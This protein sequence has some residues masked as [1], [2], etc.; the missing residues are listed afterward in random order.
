MVMA[1]KLSSVLAQQGALVHVHQQPEHE[2]QADAHAARLVHVPEHQRQRQQVGHGGLAP[3]R[4]HVEEAGD[5]QRHCDEEGVDR[6][7]QLVGTPRH[8]HGAISRC[9]TIMAQN[10]RAAAP[11]SGARP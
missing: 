4:Q 3:H 6:Q 5:G 9:R 10:R 11:W 2:G 7:Q 8:D 1:T